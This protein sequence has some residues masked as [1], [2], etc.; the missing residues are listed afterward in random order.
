MALYLLAPLLLFPEAFVCCGNSWSYPRRTAAAVVVVYPSKCSV[1]GL[2]MLPVDALSILLFRWLSIFFVSWFCRRREIPEGWHRR[3][4]RRFGWISKL[5]ILTRS[6][7]QNSNFCRWYHILFVFWIPLKPPQ[8]R[9][10]RRIWP[11]HHGAKTAV[12]KTKR[13]R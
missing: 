8:I 3:T 12:S 2:W 6:L 4:D 7:A 13:V 5:R 10:R 1:S 9:T 11:S